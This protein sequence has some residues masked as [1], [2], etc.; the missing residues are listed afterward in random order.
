M[1]GFTATNRKEFMIYKEDKITEIRDPDLTK[2]V[3]QNATKT[4][5]HEKIQAVAKV[6]HY[7]TIAKYPNGGKDVEEVIDTEPVEG[8][9]AYDEEEKIQIYVPY[10]EAELKNIKDAKEIEEL[11][12]KLTETDYES[13]KHSE[14]VLT[15]EEFA[16]TKKNRTT[17]RARINELQSEDETKTTE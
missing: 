16:D 4:V 2:G 12:I 9:D 6:S 1:S 15:D 3:L 14:G 10:T 17:W 7:E 13:I 5:H 8:K 11:K